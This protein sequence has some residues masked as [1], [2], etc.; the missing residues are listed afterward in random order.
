MAA[1]GVGNG[2]HHPSNP[3]A[4]YPHDATEQTMCRTFY[5]KYASYTGDGSGRDSYITINNG[6][7]ANNDKKFMM[8]RPAKLPRSVQPKPYKLAAAVNYRSDGT[9][10]D[11]YCVSNNGGLVSDFSCSKPEVIFK[12]GLRQ[13]YISPVRNIKDRW[14]GPDQTDYLNWMTPK[15]QAAKRAVA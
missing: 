4:R 12:S 6:G 7:L 15:D 13:H 3:M 11:S 1:R 5:P 14:R 9:G 2:G 8:W 10:R